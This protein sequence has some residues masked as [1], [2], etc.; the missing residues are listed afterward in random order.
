MIIAVVA[1][2]ARILFF[3]IQPRDPFDYLDP[4]SMAGDVL[5]LLGLLLRSWAASVIHKREELAT[6][7]PYSL[8]RHPLYAGST[9]MT[10]GF[11][12]LLGD[13]ISAAILLPVVAFTLVI[14][15]TS[16]EGILAKQFGDAWTEYCQTTPA[17][18]SVSL[19]AGWGSVSL[20]QWWVNR[21]Y[22][23]VAASML[24]MIAVVAWHMWAH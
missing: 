23:A 9:M 12:L 4:V 7:G 15:I 2:I 19:P 5:L 13:A 6:A 14:A 18:P 22:E 24:G 1:V 21:E 16:E 11:M 17:F 10:V 3:R 20:D 8:C